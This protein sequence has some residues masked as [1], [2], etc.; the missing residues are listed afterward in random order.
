M[1]I[2]QNKVRIARVEK[3]DITDPGLPV[4][5]I[6][7]FEKTRATMGAGEIGKTPQT[8]QPNRRAG[9]GSDEGPLAGPAA[10]DRDSRERHK[11]SL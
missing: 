5:D 7:V 2:A 3:L 1:I 11:G 8:A 6:E 4:V 9:R 10:M